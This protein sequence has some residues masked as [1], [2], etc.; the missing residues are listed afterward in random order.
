MSAGAGAV[1]LGL[2]VVWFRFL[3]LYI[4][5]TSAAFSIMLAVVLAGI[6][7]AASLRA[8]FQTASCRDGHLLPVLLLLAASAT[9]LSYLFFPVP[10]VSPSLPAFDRA[11]WQQTAL[12]S[13][14]LM[15]PVAFLSGILLPT[16][17]TCVQLKWAAG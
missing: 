5:S 2:E 9:L 12:L 7:S 13:L 15:F 14:V 4:A 10:A 3:R 8:S 11:F 17:V 16:V 1:L 6:G